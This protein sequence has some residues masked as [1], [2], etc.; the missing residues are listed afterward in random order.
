MKKYLK[1]FAAFC[2]VCVFSY[3]TAIYAQTANTIGGTD[4]VPGKTYDTRTG[5]PCANIATCLPGVLRNHLTGALCQVSTAHTTVTPS[6]DTFASYFADSLGLVKYGRKGFNVAILQSALAELGFLSNTNITGNSLSLTRSA[7]QAYQKKNGLR[8]D[9][10]AGGKTWAEIFKDIQSNP[11]LL[12]NLADRAKIYI[13]SS[14]SSSGAQTGFGSPA[15]PGKNVVTS[16]QAH[17]LTTANITGVA[18]VTALNNFKLFKVT[19]DSK[20]EPITEG[21]GELPKEAAFELKTGEKLL[22]AEF[23]SKDY[24]VNAVLGEFTYNG[25]AFDTNA[26][27]WQAATTTLEVAQNPSNTLLEGELKKV[28]WRQPLSLYTNEGDPYI[29][30]IS[31]KAE[32]INVDGEVKD[33]VKFYITKGSGKDALKNCEAASARACPYPYEGTEF[34][35]TM[36]ANAT[37]G[38]V[39]PHKCG[40]SNLVG[41]SAG[42]TKISAEGVQIDAQLDFS[43]GRAS[44]IPYPYGVELILIPSDG[45]P[46]TVS[47]KHV[48][49][50]PY[51]SDIGEN[52][53]K[54]SYTASPPPPLNKLTGKLA[55]VILDHDS[56]G[57][58]GFYR[59]GIFSLND[60]VMPMFAV[61]QPQILCVYPPSTPP[62]VTSTEGICRGIGADAIDVTIL[63]TLSEEVNIVGTP[64][65]QVISSNNGAVLSY[66][67][68]AGKTLKFQLITS[69]TN[70]YSSYDWYG[71]GKVKL[72][73]PSGA[74]I[75][76]LNGTDAGLEGSEWNVPPQISKC[77]V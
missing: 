37:A 57:H 17:T 22:I 76:R 50:T 65:L 42:C 24:P 28:S 46:S 59:N 48:V 14:S 43:P 7:I 75:K 32:W 45:S 1:L 53:M 29:R 19:A 56:G 72:T 10:S 67:S 49:P 52:H 60:Q 55:P 38:N 51:P 74:S 64:T 61:I 39:E 5:T 62:E 77:T 36:P 66:V 58:G 8:P 18:T 30:A 23:P 31:A 16:C 9:G 40:P 33:K 63:V 69:P 27:D 70:P 41:I 25:Y 21:G 3:G 34:N 68:K 2:L 35:C 47:L 13:T 71:N 26:G 73:I 15:T 11:D 6:S 54:F 4:C 44:V 20:I 12:R